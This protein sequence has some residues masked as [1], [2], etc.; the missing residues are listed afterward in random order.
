MHIVVQYVKHFSKNLPDLEVDSAGTK[1]VS[2]IT[3]EAREYLM[4]EDAVQYLK[5]TPEVLTVNNWSSIILL[6]LWKRDTET[7]S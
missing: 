5:K 7:Q 6:L 4:S 3:K 1:I 2:K